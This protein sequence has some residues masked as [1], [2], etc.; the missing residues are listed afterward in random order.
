MRF[1]RVVLLFL[2]RMWTGTIKS[3]R[4]GR[5]ILWLFYELLIPSRSPSPDSFAAAMGIVEQTARWKII[6][7]HEMI[8]SD[9]HRTRGSSLN[10]IIKDS[11]DDNGGIPSFTLLLSWF[12]A[13]L[14][15]PLWVHI[16]SGDSSREHD[17]GSPQ[18]EDTIFVSPR[19]PFNLTLHTSLLKET[20]TNRKRMFLFWI[21]N[22]F[23]ARAPTTL[24][25]NISSV[26]CLVSL[27][28]SI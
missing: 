6:R 27:S 25:P 18:F 24:T 26:F 2:F 15:A 4:S 1:F 11:D 8:L 20:P 16:C 5:A 7:K 3:L 9:H 28:V 21:L 19:F 10:K 12:L 17:W 14:Y 23:T 22:Y 13:S